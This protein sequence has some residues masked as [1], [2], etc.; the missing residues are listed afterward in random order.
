MINRSDDLH[1]LSDYPAGEPEGTMPASDP[2]FGKSL[3]F[4]MGRSFR[5]GRIPESH[6]GSKESQV[7][8]SV[9][10]SAAAAIAAGLM[11][12]G[13]PAFADSTGNNGINLL[14]DDNLSVLPVQ[15]CN[16]GEVVPVLSDVVDLSGHPQVHSPDTTNCSDAPIMDHP[17]IG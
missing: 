6:Q 11:S 13:A 2:L 9:R 8:T 12:L 4:P 3:P 7:R 15:V 17:T 14:D 1:P 10:V 5:T 16:N